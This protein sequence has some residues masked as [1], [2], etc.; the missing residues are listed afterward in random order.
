[1]KIYIAGHNGMA[2]SAIK[3]EF[4]ANNFTDIVV[5]NKS[6]LDLINQQDVLNFFNDQKPDIVILAAA[7]VGGIQANISSPFNFLFENLNTMEMA[8]M[9]NLCILAIFFK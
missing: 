9:R 3:K 8:M 7:K 2:G 6:E 5:R 1:M 4:E